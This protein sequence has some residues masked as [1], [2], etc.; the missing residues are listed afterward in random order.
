M[1]TDLLKICSK[2]K[3][4]KNKTNQKKKK[5]QKNQKTL[6]I[7][8]RKTSTYT[9]SSLNEVYLKKQDGAD[10]DENWEDWAGG[11]FIL[12]TPAKHHV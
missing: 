11:V 4:T 9:V 12:R 3:Q 8:Q 6:Q 5:K 7:H 10:G 1:L 2:K